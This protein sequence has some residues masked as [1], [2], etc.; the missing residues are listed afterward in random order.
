MS[1]VAVFCMLIVYVGESFICPLQKHC[2]EE[3]C[4]LFLRL[5]FCSGSVSKNKS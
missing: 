1:F 3:A 5:P 4:L 2:A